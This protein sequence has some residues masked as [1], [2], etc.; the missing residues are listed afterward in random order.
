MDT[1][2]VLDINQAQGIR[3]ELHEEDGK[4]VFKKTYDAEPF[5]E[6]AAEARALS[7]GQ[8]WGEEGRHVGFIPMAE[9]ATMMRRDGSFD[10][11]EIR[12]WLKAN[13]KFVTFERYLK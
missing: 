3:T 2:K 13:P 9:L 5:L 7:A 12:K 1:L 6:E 4:L 8:R 11:K 10:K